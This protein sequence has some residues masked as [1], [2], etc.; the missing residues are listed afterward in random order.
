MQANTTR[1]PALQPPRISDGDRLGMTFFLAAC[2]HGI[3]ILG[4]TF[5]M[6]PRANENP[7]ALDIILV[8]TSSPAETEDADFLAQVTQQGGGDSE[9]NIRPQDLFTAPNLTDN[10]GL[11]L[12]TADKQV[13]R[14]QRQE[15]Q[16]LL[17]ARKSEQRINND[18][19]IEFEDQEQ[20]LNQDNAAEAA[21]AARMA[22]EIN[23]RIETAA[24]SGKAKYLNSSTREFAPARY[25]RHWINRVERIGNLNYPD[26]ARRE[27]LSGT[28]ILNVVIDAEGQLL[29]TDLRRSS[30]H[31]VLD[32][33]ARRI[34]SLASPFEPFPEKLKSE[35]D[36]IHITR[37]WEF[38]TANQLKTR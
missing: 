11:A 29:R 4:I 23:S 12:Q 5:S 26:Q 27:Q 3:L 7:P 25:M 24:S 13:N 1:N 15:Q 30:G 2:L 6:A 38:S 34:V 8:Q 32:D 33:A 19:D 21:H 14:Q 36:I 9:E 10:P 18:R 20:Q 28:L 16:Q 22:Q 37:S 17:V 35:T 31:R